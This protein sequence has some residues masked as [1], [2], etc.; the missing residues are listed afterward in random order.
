MLADM[1]L[2]E[3][4][5]IAHTAIVRHQPGPVWPA[6]WDRQLQLPRNHRIVAV[7]ADHEGCAKLLAATVDGGGNA[8]NL[9]IFAND[10]PHMGALADSDTPGFRPF[11]QQVIKGESGKP[12]RCASRLGFGEI[13]HE[14]AAVRRV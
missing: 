10:L 8:D 3:T 4:I 2:A 1:H 14:A 6:Q 13:R 12:E 9:P 7:S 11:Q 5:E